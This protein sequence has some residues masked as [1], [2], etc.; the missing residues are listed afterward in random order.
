MHLWKNQLGEGPVAG[1]FLAF[2]LTNGI[3]Y[4]IVV[5]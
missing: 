5:T 4:A 2:F 3:F 1:F